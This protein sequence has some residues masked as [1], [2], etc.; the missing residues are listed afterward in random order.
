[1][2][3][4]PPLKRRRGLGRAA[5]ATAT[6][7]AAAALLAAP[8]TASAQDAVDCSALG[9][10]PSADGLAAALRIA[11]ACDV[12]VRLEAESSPYAT[13]YVTPQWQLRYVGTAGPVQGDSAG[14]TADPVLVESGDALVVDG[15]PW[16]VGLSRTDT[17]GP[18]L[19]DGA[20]ALDWVGE[21]PVPEYS[22]T[23][24]TYGE[25][26]PGLDLTVEAGVSTTQ[27][28]FTVDGP[29]AWDALASGLTVSSD[30]GTFSRFPGLF[31][32]LTYGD[33]GTHP[34]I[35]AL[36]PFK[37]RDADGTGLTVRV[38]QTSNGSETV[39]LW[40][41]T[42]P[43]ADLAFPL[44]VTTEWISVNRQVNEWGAV[45]SA[46]QTLPI[47]RGGA[48]LDE[49]YFTAAGEA[50][51][52]VVGPYCDLLADPECTEVHEAA[53][54]WDFE[55]PGRTTLNPAGAAWL[56]YPLVSATFSIDAAAGA[57]CVAPDLSAT[58]VDGY[59]AGHVW[60]YRDT[61]GSPAASGECI[62]GTAVYDITG[63]IP[64]PSSFNLAMLGSEETARFDGGSARLEVVRDIRGLDF[65]GAA[66]RV[67]STG[68]ALTAYSND[69]TPQYGGFKV[70]DWDGLTAALDLSWTATFRDD[71]GATALATAPR[72]LVLGTTT[73][74]Y[75]PE[76]PLPDGRY[77]V[78]YTFTS[79]DGAFTHTPM[80][81][82]IAVDT[83]APEVV[84][85]DVDDRQRYVGEEFEVT[86]EV[87]DDGFPADWRYLTLHCLYSGCEIEGSSET[88]TVRFTD[89]STATFPVTLESTGLELP[90]S[91]YDKANNQD[92]A[93]V[94][95]PATYS[96]ND[97]D[98]DGHQDL[99]AV[100]EA[101]GHML[102]HAGN[103]DGT[104]D[105]G[106][107]K[108]AGW[109]GVDAAMAGDLNGDGR[110]D[111]LGRDTRTGSLYLYPG[112]GAGGWSTRV[113][114]SAGWN[115]TGAFTSGADVNR[116]G[117]ADLLAVKQ[118]DGRLYSYPGKGDGTF[119]TG[120]AIASG[121]GGFDAVTAAGDLDE[122]GY[123]D[124]LAR[125]A[126]T[127]GHYLYFGNGSGFGDRVAVPA[128][129]DGTGTDRY[130]QVTPVGD[131]DGDNA[132]DLVAIDSRTGEL[133]LH[134]LRGDGTALHEGETVA[135][136]W[137][138][139]RLASA[140]DDRTYDYTGDGNSDVLARRGSDGKLYVYNGNGST[141]FGPIGTWGIDLKGLTLLE[142][143][144][145]FDGDGF[146]DL[147]GRDSGGILYLYRGDGTGGY[148]P[149]RRL[150]IG[151]GWNGM[152]AV[153]SGQDFDSDGFADI[154]GRDQATGYLWLY[155]GRGDGTIG[156]KVQ[157]STG[158]NGMREITSP[159]DLDH[160]GHADVIGIRSSND[161]MYFYGG[162]GDGTLKAGVQVSCNWTGYDQVAAVGDFDGDGHGDWIA[163]RVADGRVY[164]YQGTGTGGFTTRITLVT[165]WTWANA[166]A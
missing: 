15:T 124:L 101:D 140:A 95:V 125:D 34:H 155:P 40:P 4:T 43:I 41:P 138:G 79:A 14:E 130:R 63:P 46:A 30:I 161:C 5:A 166:I 106:V 107:S 134:S 163:R 83:A 147:L 24:A 35:G 110:A 7:V 13:T 9:S 154:V 22:G 60:K 144:G 152:S 74:F 122:D 102:F 32:V 61:E 118:S 25:L 16:P 150:R 111:L 70:D 66:Q 93:S 29:E 80:P 58:S 112:N 47:Y 67:C 36:T 99:M 162:K 69:A 44:A 128:G 65:K 98:G 127:G 53:G 117:R 45:T 126:R 88:L 57:E 136:G 114:I 131:V 33:F 8:G 6:A 19:T 52:L 85:L 104:F 160:D 94:S 148:D 165:G 135:T 54:Y 159:G 81:C 82:S 100:R 27:L 77:E 149:A 157:F 143:A 145:D 123:D 113:L 91:L 59:H 1:M 62:D 12:E 2:S 55:V 137:G 129:L 72:D 17:D 97:F 158:W 18:L 86:V 156:A 20:A 49:P 164:L 76:A 133:E 132:E 39:V 37:I 87:A 3:E 146:A 10:L 64:D 119:G 109:G 120:T 121:W 105:A 50:G 115:T 92:L 103:G 90:V 108:G 141:G 42:Q 68:T 142:T 21:Q 31:S 73:P 71:T 26:T 84:V 48:G 56:N 116:D 139:S 75:S 151:S 51:D 11:T 153:V 38:H 96:R 28:R 23:T 78:T 89:E